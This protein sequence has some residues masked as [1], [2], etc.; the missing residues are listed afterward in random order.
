MHPFATGRTS[1][2]CP[3]PRMLPAP[4]LGL[5]R[6]FDKVRCVDAGGSETPPREK[7]PENRKK[8][9]FFSIFFKV[10]A[11]APCSALKL[12]ISKVPAE[13]HCER[14]RSRDSSAA[15]D[16]DT[17]AEHHHRSSLRAHHH[18]RCH[19]RTR[20]KKPEVTKTFAGPT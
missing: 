2:W 20:K 4:S 17:P 15:T 13:S 8:V 10:S 14:E 3:Q 16:D 11:V 1:T 5:Q 6:S 7:F 19:S 18:Q 9:L 12:F